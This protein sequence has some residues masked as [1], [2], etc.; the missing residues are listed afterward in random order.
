VLLLFFY[1]DIYLKN[2][3]SFIS[4]TSPLCSAL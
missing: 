2:G 1:F 3:W 4:N